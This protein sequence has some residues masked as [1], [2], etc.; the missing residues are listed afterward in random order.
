MGSPAW[1][2]D[3]TYCL[4]VDYS[5]VP[6]L[7]NYRKITLII[8]V[9]TC[10]SVAVT[11]DG[12]AVSATYTA[13][14]GTA[15]F[16]TTGQSIV[17]TAQN[18]TAGGTGAATK[19][20]LYNNYHW[21]YSLTFDDNRLSQYDYGKPLLDALGWRAGEAVVG[22][23]A[24]QGGASGSGSYF[25][26]WTCLQNLRAAGW[27]MYDLS[28]DHPNPLTC[29]G[30]ATD[31]DPELANNQ[32]LLLKYFPG[33]NVSQMVFPYENSTANT[34]S[35]YP[36]AYIMSAECGGGSYNYVDTT[37]LFQVQRGGMFGTDDTAWKSLAAS[38]AGSSR[39]TWLVEYTHSVSEGSGA[40]ADEYSTNQTTL[41]DLLNYLNTNFGTPGNQ[42]MWFAPA[43]EV[44]DY[45][46]TRD[47]AVVTTCTSA[48]TPTF[49]STP[50][51]TDTPTP[52][53]T[54]TPTIT[55]TKTFTAMNTP[56]STPTST[57][58]RT[59]TATNTFTNTF[60]HTFTQVNTPTPT[61]TNTF[62]QVNTP[63]ST[64]TPV[65]TNTPTFTLVNTST[66]TFTNTNTFTY[67][68][69]A[70]DTWTPV[71]TN[72]PTFT[73]VNTTTSTWTGTSTDTKT[74]TPVNT[75]TATP[76]HTWTAVW[77]DTVTFTAT[78]TPLFTKTP[79]STPAVAF[80]PTSTNTFTSVWTATATRTPTETFTSTWTRTV[81][82][83]PTSTF[84]LVPTFTATDSMTAT[85]TNTFTDTITPTQTPTNTNTLTQTFTPTQTYTPTPTH[86]QAPTPLPG[87]VGIYPNPAPGETVTILPPYYSDF[88][89]VR[90]EVFTLGF[91]KVIDQTVDSIQTGTPIAV[92]LVGRFG[93]P[94]ANGL[95]YVVVTTT[96]GRTI[97]KL[98]VIK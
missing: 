91:R 22:S 55:F 94:L 81:T 98:L 47:N 61:L 71:F 40:A 24:N 7:V 42:S 62:T 66:P 2:T 31:I 33:Y 26:N 16:T 43:G 17:V 8:N 93:N 76:T 90:V 30:S 21:A 85:T 5:S 1:A 50:T 37:L 44:R 95:Y 68:N 69:T 75:P 64:L 18:W 46:F 53:N 23:W 36:P 67:V 57:N 49:T 29:N 48:P 80:S 41:S 92:R 63:T 6:T 39:P 34:C 15:V 96:A 54:N 65:W 86:T 82:L 87:H 28:Y 4:Q 11:V 56:S 20:T 38:A 52:T 73:L 45:L 59:S 60:T 10:A 83:T 19:A 78:N 97:G 35:G 27:D 12:A 89:N 77:S 70:T 72:T 32:P 51:S 3:K 74:F 13:S 9:G 88:S 84:S 25:M 79:S 58:T 14:S